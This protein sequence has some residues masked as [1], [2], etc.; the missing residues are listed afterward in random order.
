MFLVDDALL[1]PFKG[2]L[3]IVREIHK[4]AIEDTKNEAE[5]IRQDL[6]QL[7]RQLET[8]EISESEFDQHERQLLDR[9]DAVEARS[10]P[11][12][13]DS[14]RDSESGE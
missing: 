10:R 1:C 7:Y 8:G 12:P 6:S 14:L 13:E 3:W 4:A 9:L 5:A 2:F 11:D